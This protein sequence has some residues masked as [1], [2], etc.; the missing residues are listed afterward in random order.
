MSYYANSTWKFNAY[1]IGK[2]PHVGASLVSDS[3]LLGSKG[4]QWSLQPC[5]SQ[6]LNLQSQRSAVCN[7]TRINLSGAAGMMLIDS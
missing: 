1:Q 2:L 5:N 4:I 6:I 3:S 7:L